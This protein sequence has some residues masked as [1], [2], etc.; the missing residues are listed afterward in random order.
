MKYCTNKEIDHLVRD[1]VKQGWHFSWGSKHGRLSPPQG[2]AKITVP[3]SPSDC[4]AAQNF[5]HDIRRI[6]NSKKVGN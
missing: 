2:A 5:S 6:L 3:K 1:L 4:R